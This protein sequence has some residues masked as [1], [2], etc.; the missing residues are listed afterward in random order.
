MI[1]HEDI[2]YSNMK[3]LV[4]TID[5]LYTIFPYVKLKNG[6]LQLITPRFGE[7]ATQ[8]QLSNYILQT[9][10]QLGM[11]KRIREEYF[12]RSIDTSIKEDIIFNGFKEAPKNLSEY[13]KGDIQFLPTML[14][15]PNEA[16]Y[17]EPIYSSRNSEF[18]MFTL[19]HQIEVEDGKALNG[20]VIG[21]EFERVI[22]SLSVQSEYDRIV[23]D[24]RF[25]GGLPHS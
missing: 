16:V 7:K 15:M 4:F 14:Q 17:K 11:D 22:F 8:K 6:E 24:S 12:K 2:V 19:L 9:F 5:K 13:T 10:I 23:Y 3:I 20:L 25:I 1:I 21:D 18:N